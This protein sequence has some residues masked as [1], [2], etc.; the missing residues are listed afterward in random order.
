MGL[1]PLDPTEMDTHVVEMLAKELHARKRKGK[2]LGESSKRA[3][4]AVPCPVALASASTAFEAAESIE[5]APITK[6]GV[7]DG[8]SM[9]PTSLSL[10]AKKEK[11]GEKKKK[12]KKL[13]IIKV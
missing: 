11:G 13:T 2:V 10:S 4:I 3:K 1:S 6:V 5:V 9:P 12:K 8:G 7:S